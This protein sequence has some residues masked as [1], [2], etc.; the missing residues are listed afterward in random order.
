MSS[1]IPEADI[2]AACRVPVIALLVGNVESFV[3]SFSAI[4]VAVVVDCRKK[5]LKS[6]ARLQKGVGAVVTSTISEV[7]ID[8]PRIHSERNIHCRA[9]AVRANSAS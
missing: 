6:T 8:Q 3:V 5:L 7:N 2:S 4:T 1:S 9:W